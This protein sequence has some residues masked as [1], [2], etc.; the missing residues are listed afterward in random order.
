[1]ELVS[2]AT[3]ETLFLPR[4][5]ELDETLIELLASAYHVDNFDLE[6]LTLDAKRELIRESILNHRIKGTPA[7]VEKIA[8]HVFRD[9][10]V[11]EWFEYGGKPYYFRIMQDITETEESADFE[12]MNRLRR[13]VTETKNVRSHLEFFGFIHD[14]EESEEVEDDQTLLVDRVYEDWYTYRRDNTR[15]DGASDVDRG[16][17]IRHNGTLRRDGQSRRRGWFTN[18]NH[19]QYQ[20]SDFEVIEVIMELEPRG[21]T[22]AAS[23]DAFEKILFKSKHDSVFPED[24]RTTEVLRN[25]EDAFPE[26]TQEHDMGVTLSGLG[27]ECAPLPEHQ[28]AIAIEVNDDQSIGTTFSVVTVG[29]TIGEEVEVGDNYGDL[30]V[31]LDMAQPVEYYDSNE[32]AVIYDREE[33]IPVSDEMSEPDRRFSHHE[34]I[35]E[36]DERGVATVLA[37]PFDTVGSEEV[38]DIGLYQYVR[39]NGK[40]QHNGAIRHCG[41][42]TTTVHFE[43]E[44]EQRAF[45]L[46]VSEVRADC[47]DPCT[48]CGCRDF[49]FVHG[50]VRFGDREF[51]ITD[52]QISTVRVI[53]RNCGN[54]IAEYLIPNS[55]WEAI[56]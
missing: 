7:A 41:V 23:D 21:D 1:M 50:A 9:A 32:P 18:A 4:L 2:E 52:L 38:G 54:I 15:Y 56:L 10:Q 3:W 8:R 48:N 35:G 27:D 42:L 13:A 19:G 11:I 33:S 40:H 20:A 30:D 45:D 43:D 29:H 28:L 5:N 46:M 49:D 6:P 12:L 14:F 24:S 22:V 39:H 47:A 17:Y 25:S 53:C 16:R 26:V 55:D 34:E 44:S 36:T 37:T 31:T 51:L